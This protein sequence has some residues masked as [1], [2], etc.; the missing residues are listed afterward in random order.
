MAPRPDGTCQ[1]LTAGKCTI[2]ENRPQT[3]LDYDCRVFAAAGIEAGKPV[4]DRR[5]REWQFS[6]PTGADRKAHDA[7]L[8]AA[9]FI[10]EKRTNFPANRA[11]VAPTGIAVLAIK[12]Y[13]VFLEQNL[14]RRSDAEVATAIVDA[15]RA[16]DADAHA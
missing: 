15:G 6:Y 9:A 1:M 12:T 13:T 5:V 14:E 2:Y 7:V 10:R 11:P 4:I 8:A 3:C 16:F